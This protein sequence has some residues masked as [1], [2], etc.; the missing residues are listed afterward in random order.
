MH[1]STYASHI[2]LRPLIITIHYDIMYSDNQ[3]RNAQHRNLMLYLLVRR[4]KTGVERLRV[5]R[6]RKHRDVQID[7]HMHKWGS[8]H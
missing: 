5:S 2:S 3:S 8:V 6:K 7:E 4:G 1:H